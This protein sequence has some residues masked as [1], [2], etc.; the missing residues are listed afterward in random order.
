MNPRC[1]Q[2]ELK[3]FKLSETQGNVS[4]SNV[5]LYLSFELSRKGLN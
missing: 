1:R 3:D 2:V 4:F 5:T